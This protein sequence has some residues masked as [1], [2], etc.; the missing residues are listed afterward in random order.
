[1][2]LYFLA[3]MLFASFLWP[4]IDALATVILTWLEV[5]KGKLSV[6]LALM[7]KDVQDKLTP[8]EPPKRQIGFCVPAPIE[9]E[10]EDEEDYDD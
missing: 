3:G 9:V 8:E 5:L 7:Q 2:L 4:I 10:E 1:M 6:K